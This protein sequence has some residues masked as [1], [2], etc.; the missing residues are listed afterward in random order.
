MIPP[1][2]KDPLRA[3]GKVK[4]Q[5]VQM[6]KTFHGIYVKKYAKFGENREKISTLDLRPGEV[7]NNEKFHFKIKSQT[8]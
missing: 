3:R 2:S 1:T 7:Y 8:I 4:I 5:F 6:K